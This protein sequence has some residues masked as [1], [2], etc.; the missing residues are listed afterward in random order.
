[1][2]RGSGA[3]S[4]FTA[5]E[6]LHF[7]YEVVDAG[8]RVVWLLDLRM[9]GRSSGIEVA[10]GKHAWVIAFKDGLMIQTSST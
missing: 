5:W 6:A 8:E 1:M 10:I 3:A 2:A 9:R 7:E 4:W